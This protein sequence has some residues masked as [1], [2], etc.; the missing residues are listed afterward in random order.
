[1][2]F[3][4]LGADLAPQHGA[5]TLLAVRAPWIPVPVREMYE[6]PSET[7]RSSIVSDHDLGS[8][9]LRPRAR[10]SLRPTPPSFGSTAWA[11]DPAT[12]SSTRPH[13]WY[14]HPPSSTSA[15]R[16]RSPIVSGDVPHSVGPLPGF[17]MINDPVLSSR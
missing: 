10:P 8:V 12:S 16:P 7:R 13:C 5:V 11:H 9:C 4:L 17:G 3:C 14:P 1:M 2:R 15:S 6:T